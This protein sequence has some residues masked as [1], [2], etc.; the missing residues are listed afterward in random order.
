MENN[1]GFIRDNI[2]IKILLLFILDRLSSPV[3]L[4]TLSQLTMT[5]GGVDYFSFKQCLAELV[6]T[7]HIEEQNGRYVITEK[8]RRNGRITE[9]DIPYSVRLQAEKN[10]GE[11][12]EHLKRGALIQAS[13]TLRNRG[14]CDV[15]LSLSDGISEIFS[16]ELLAGSEDQ[17][18]HIEESFREKAEE[19]YATVL[20]ALCE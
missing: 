9:K 20:S 13:H 8:G 12:N 3:D 17:A 10:A 11:L 4:D 7:E 2:D 16:M 14:G 15:K 1:Y 5:D 6:S 19:L 18:R